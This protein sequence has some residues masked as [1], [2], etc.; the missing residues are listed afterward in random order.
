MDLKTLCADLGNAKAHLDIVRKE[1]LT[2]KQKGAL[3]MACEILAKL[4]G[5]AKREQDG[6]SSG[7]AFPGIDFP[8]D[9]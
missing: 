9:F 2:D 5:A 6:G 3:D 8:P 1:A 4:Y 7:E